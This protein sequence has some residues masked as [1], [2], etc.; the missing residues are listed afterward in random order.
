MAL[1]VELLRGSFA[2]VAEREPE[3][4]HRFYDNLF[5]SYPAAQPLFGRRTRQDQ[6]KML[7]DMLVAVIDHLEDASWLTS[8]LGALGAKHMDY[9]VTPEMYGWVGASLLKT[10]EQVAGKDW[11]PELASAWAEAYGAIAGLMQSGAKSA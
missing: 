2:L 8:Q 4:T 5:A 11:S 7:R 10:L 6:E 3:L 1:N 9:G